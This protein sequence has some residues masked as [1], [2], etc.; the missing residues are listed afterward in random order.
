LAIKF[1]QTDVD[2]IRKWFT[3]F[4]CKM[5]EDLN[6]SLAKYEETKTLDDDSVR[7]LKIAFVSAVRNA[8]HPLAGD[9]VW[10]EVDE[11]LDKHIYQEAFDRDI[12]KIIETPK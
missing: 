11:T 1:D 3:Y 12:K 8:D 10:N 5:P 4:K 2:N 9:P 7:E 6:K